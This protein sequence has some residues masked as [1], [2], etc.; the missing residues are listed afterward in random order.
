MRSRFLKK[1]NETVYGD[2]PDVQMFAEE[3]T[4]WPMVSRADRHAAGS[5]SG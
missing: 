3:S 1:L 5:G 2:F 4:A